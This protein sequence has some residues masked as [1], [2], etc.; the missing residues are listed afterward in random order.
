M[1]TISAVSLKV[2]SRCLELGAASAHYVA[3]TMEDMT[4][5]EQF[6][7]KAGKLM[8]KTPSPPSLFLLWS[9]S[10][11]GVGKEQDGP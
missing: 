6:V 10:V 11:S 7:L 4:F 1:A 8:G 5:A 2:V 3:G 9:Q